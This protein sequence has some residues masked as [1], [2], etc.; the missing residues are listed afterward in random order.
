MGNY[1][2]TRFYKHNSIYF[3]VWGYS[4]YNFN[5]GL[6]MEFKFDNESAYLDAHEYMLRVLQTFY[7]NKN[8][9][10]LEINDCDKEM[11]QRMKDYGGVIIDE[12]RETVSRPIYTAY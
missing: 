5:K 4:K 10:I 11:K 7:Y 12:N 6:N 8:N 3:V 1:R 9:K 2:D